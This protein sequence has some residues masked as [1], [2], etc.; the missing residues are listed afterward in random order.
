MSALSSRIQEASRCSTPYRGALRRARYL[1]EFFEP[2]LAKSAGQLKRRLHQT[3]KPLAQVHDRPRRDMQMAI[4][5][6]KR[7]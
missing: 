7:L 3:E 5:D 4:D 6:S 1:G 2:V